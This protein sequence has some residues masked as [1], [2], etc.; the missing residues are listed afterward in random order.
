M[1]IRSRPLLITLVCAAQL[2]C[3]CG[4][5]AAFASWLERD[6]SAAVRRQVLADNRQVA[7]QMA[8]MIRAMRL[9]DV[10]P[11]SPDWS[12]L[13]AAVEQVRLP[14][15]GFVCV[16]GTAS[17]NILCHPQLRSDPRLA[18]TPLGR[19]VLSGDGPPRTIADT[20]GGGGGTA[21][22]GGDVHLIGV[23][24]VPSLGVKVLA[25]QA[26][27]GVTAAATATV[28]P[29]RRAGVLAAVGLTV[30]TGVVTAVV[31]RRYEDRLA[32][33]NARLERLVEARSRALMRTR[34][35]VIFGLA[36]LAESRDDDTGSHLERVGRY[37]ELL[38]GEF[39]TVDVPLLVRASSLHDIGKVGIPDAVLCKPGKLT[40]DE[41]TTMQRHPAIGGDCLAAI[42]G[43][44][45]EDDFLA[46]ALDTALT[47]HE[48]W[49]GTGYPRGLAR[50]EIPLA[51]RIMAVAD[52]YDALTSR[53]VYKAAMPHETAAAILVQ[54][55]G[56]QFDPAVVAAFVRQQ[57]AFAAVARH[58]NPSQAAAA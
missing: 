2:A 25:H 4:A 16:V 23:S 50:D 40:A 5:L 47:H 54:G 52:V 32:A 1:P 38:A 19:T 20:P 15:Q 11:G 56:S 42:K 46:T 37:V 28:G 14:N 34:D 53:R 6:L 48:R 27:A 51:G 49:D 26:D 9:H 35:A 12:R 22:I 45:G 57:R 55:S 58:A 36:K 18:R 39:P 33:A 29:V 31:V 21:V 17:G 7:A 30:L 13:Q 10:T 41:R 44:L 3:L 8:T 43:R 24:D